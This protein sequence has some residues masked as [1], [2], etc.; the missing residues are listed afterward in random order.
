MP[1]PSSTHP[2]DRIP[3]PLDAVR[4]FVE[5]FARSPLRAF[6]IIFLLSFAVQCFFMTKVPQ[7]WVRPHTRWE[8]PAIAVSRPSSNG[9]PSA[10]RRW[11]REPGKPWSPVPLL[12]LLT[13]R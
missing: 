1:E 5:W 3:N 13:T 12:P 9:V 4:A 6:I 7:R 10:N 11:C 2:A 8:M